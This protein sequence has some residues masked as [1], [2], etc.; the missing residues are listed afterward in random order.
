MTESMPGS[1]EL[2][3]A[4]QP[5]PVA[6]P[7]EAR[8]ISVLSWDTDVN[9]PEKDFRPLP[10]PAAEP[11]KTPEQ[12]VEEELTD[13]KDSS[14]A[15]PVDSSDAAGQMEK[16]SL[17]TSEETASKPAEKVSTKVK[18]PVVGSPIS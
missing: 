18:A 6:K 9:R 15:E 13:P 16:L 11:F 17:E 7:D 3:G 12:L 2:A 8:E 10:T 4:S 14:A 5:A 1:H